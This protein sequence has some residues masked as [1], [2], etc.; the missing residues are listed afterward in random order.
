MNGLIFNIKRFAIHDGP[1]I[2]VTFF[3]KGCPLSCWWCHN[4]EGISPEI[5]NIERVDRI[6]EREFRVAEKVGQRYDI[7]DLVQIVKKEE[8]FIEESGGGIT[9]SGGEPLMQGD[10]VLEALRVFREMKIHTCIDTSGHFD[11]AIIESLIPYTDLFLFDIKHLNDEIHKKY[12]GVSNSLVLS[13]YT[14]ILEAGSDVYIRIPI[15]PGINDDRLHLEELKSFLVNSG[16][17][18]IKRV[19]LLPYHKI[20][21]SKYRR[22]GLEYKMDGI[23]QPSD[24]RMNELKGFFEEP[25]FKVKIG[26]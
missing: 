23:E 20:G 4:P 22:F 19:D 25:G 11:P 2:R 21:Y 16:E 6:G 14:R 5:Q 9:F 13:N 12:T 24:K 26:G 18:N 1:G 10:F 3:M 17:G 8:V 15:I 7:E